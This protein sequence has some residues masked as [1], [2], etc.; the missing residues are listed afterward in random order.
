MTSVVNDVLVLSRSC[1]NWCCVMCVVASVESVDVGTVV[2]VDLSS[3]DVT[4]ADECS[5]L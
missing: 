3:L 1:A 5:V 4:C 2:A